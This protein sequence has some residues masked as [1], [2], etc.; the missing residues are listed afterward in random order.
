MAASESHTLYRTS[1]GPGPD[2]RL[3]AWAEYRNLGGSV[4]TSKQ[5]RMLSAEMLTLIRWRG[6]RW[7]CS[8]APVFSLA[9]KE[10]TRMS[11]RCRK[12]G[13]GSDASS[14]A[15]CCSKCLS[16]RKFTF[17]GSST[18]P[19][20]WPVR[21]PSLLDHCMAVGA[22]FEYPGIRNISLAQGHLAVPW[23]SYSSEIVPLRAWGRSPLLRLG[24]RL[25]LSREEIPLMREGTGP[26][27]Q[28]MLYLMVWTKESCRPQRSGAG[29]RRFTPRTPG[30]ARLELSSLLWNLVWRAN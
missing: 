16:D 4:T 7:I 26:A 1:G 2:E 21:P 13:L 23:P 24:P 30:H 27:R 10:K 12:A 29:C 15:M 18:T 3:D 25:R 5:A 14:R 22:G 8:P 28:C 19:D 11:N 9:R 6:R 17:G 20:H